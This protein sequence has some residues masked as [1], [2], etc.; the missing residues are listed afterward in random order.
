MPPAV[1]QIT[2]LREKTRDARRLMRFSKFLFETGCWLCGFGPGSDPSGR[3]LR[4]CHQ[5]RA[6]KGMLL[7]Q[8]FLTFPKRTPLWMLK[9]Y[10]F[11]AF[12]TW[13]WLH[14]C[15]VTIKKYMT[16]SYLEFSVNLKWI[17]FNNHHKDN[18]FLRIAVCKYY[19]YSADVI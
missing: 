11:P 2:D 14:V 3:S 9:K 1:P 6:C 5:L 15:Y 12:P 19:I 4:C 18:I 16:P 13:E 8:D 7:V 10:I 17:H